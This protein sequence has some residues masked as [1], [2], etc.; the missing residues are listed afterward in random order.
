MPWA[1]SFSRCLEKRYDNSSTQNNSKEIVNNYRPV[2]VLPICSEIFKKL[3]FDSI[4][5]FSD[6]KNLFSN[7]QSRFR[8]SDSCTH[9]LIAI[10]H[11][12]FSGFSGSLS[13][14]VRGVL[15][16]L[17]K[18]FDRVWQDGLPYKRKVDGIEDN[19]FKLIKSFL[20]N[21]CQTGCSQWSV[22]SLVIG[23]SWRAASFNS[24][25]IIFSYL[26]YGPSS[27]SYY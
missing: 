4:Y 27:R 16:D 22:F 8:P 24:R 19:L 5:D 6:K 15:L 25:S 2:S 9:Q 26:L 13:L 23:N 7:K 3:I 21:R 10:T 14:E 12:I 18:A 1:W 20:N 17:F 11:N